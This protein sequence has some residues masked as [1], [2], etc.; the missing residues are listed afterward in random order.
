MREHVEA[1]RRLVQVVLVSPG[2]RVMLAE[3]KSARSAASFWALD[4]LR[5][6]IPG[7]IVVDR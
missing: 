7:L 3:R 6:R 5:R 2:C 1:G 4:A